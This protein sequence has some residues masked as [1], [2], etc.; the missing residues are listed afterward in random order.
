MFP[1]CVCVLVVTQITGDVFV[2]SGAHDT[3]T[4]ITLNMFRG[5]F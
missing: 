4:T 1:V 2:L 5:V 3:L